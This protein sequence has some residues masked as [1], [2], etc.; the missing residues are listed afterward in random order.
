MSKETREECYRFFE[1][2]Y[3]QGDWDTIV[4]WIDANFI[5]KKDIGRTE[6]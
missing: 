2:N 6:E 1:E 5:S 3:I 4:D